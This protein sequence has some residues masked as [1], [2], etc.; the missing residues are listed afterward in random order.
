MIVPVPPTAGDV[1][2]QPGAL[3]ETNVVLAGVGSVTVTVDAFSGPGLLT[4]IEYAMSWFCP[5]EPAPFLV[6]VRFCAGVVNT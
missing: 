4:V 6:I 1:I 2:V 3:A 5:T